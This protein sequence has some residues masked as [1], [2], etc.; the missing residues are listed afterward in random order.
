MSDPTVDTPTPEMTDAS[1]EAAPEAVDAGPAVEASAGEATAEEAAGEAPAEAAA[2]VAEAAG[3]EAAAEAPA[4]AAA[5]APPE[6]DPVAVE[7]AAEAAAESTA[8]VTGEVETDPVAVEAAAEAAAGETPEAASAPEAAA[9]AEAPPAEAA[10]AEAAPA[11]AKGERKAKGEG[12]KHQIKERAEDSGGVSEVPPVD[13]S[14]LSEEMLALVAAMEGK[15][16]IEGKVIGWNK[17][18]YHVAIGK[19]AAFCPVSQME[20]GN[21]RS[22]KKY[23]DKPFMFHVMEIQQNGRRVVVSRQGVIRKEREA[24]AAK[25]RENVKVGAELQGRVSSIT[26]FGA[27]VDLGGGV[28]GLVHVSELSRR[29]VEHA[30]EL[31]QVGQTVKVSVLKVEKNGKR[32]SLSMKKL[33]ADPWDLLPETLQPGSE[34][35]GKVMRK[36]EFGLFIEVLPGV[37]GLAHTSRLQLGTTLADAVYEPGSPV[38]GWVQEVDK[39]RRRLSLSL[40]E[41]A[42]S[43]PWKGIG[44]RYPEGQMVQGKVE[45]LTNFGVFIELEPGLTG[46]LAFAQLTGAGNPKRQFQVGRQVSVRVLSVD[47]DKKRISLGTEASRAEGGQSDFRDYVRQ[48]RESTGMGALAAALAKARGAS[49]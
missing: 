18:G 43:N 46:L 32:I 31:V 45:K 10:P 1:P 15:N 16:P 8:E 12:D 3:D 19:I 30:K 14:Q 20:I 7:A 49:Q 17:G 13:I 24:A 34:F 38:K 11:P 28:E 36:S 47:R 5:E 41:I 23:L 9:S 25:V 29:R 22:P 33:E 39:K 4:E 27:F 44:D 6:A 42:T 40:R 48:Q 35:E 21:P 2:A 26:D 37:E